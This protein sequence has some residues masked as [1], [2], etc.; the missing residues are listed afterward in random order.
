[1]VRYNTGGAGKLEYYNGLIWTSSA[2]PT[3]VQR[4]ATS[5]TKITCGFSS[6][7]ECLPGETATSGGAIVINGALEQSYAETNES[8]NIT[9]WQMV[10]RNTGTSSCTINDHVADGT[11]ATAVPPA[12]P[13]FDLGSGAYIWGAATVIC[14][15]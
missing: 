5:A 15:H 3:C 2:I 7:V 10:G 14:C 8:G 9:G 6:H 13:R 1:M 12:L 4:K 11:V